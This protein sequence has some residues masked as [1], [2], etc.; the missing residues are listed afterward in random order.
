MDAAE[1][2][3]YVQR[4]NESSAKEMAITEAVT[5]TL[6]KIP[7]AHSSTSENTTSKPNEV[8]L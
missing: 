1:A 7:Q 2:I 8:F 5:D 6:L 4:S 3:A